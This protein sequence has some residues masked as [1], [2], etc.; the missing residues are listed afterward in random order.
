MKE[1]VIDII[2]PELFNSTFTLLTDTVLGTLNKT[3]EDKY[4]LILT[5]PPYVTSGAVI[6]KMQ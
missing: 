2:I 1:R 6:I 5:N 3:E 4:D